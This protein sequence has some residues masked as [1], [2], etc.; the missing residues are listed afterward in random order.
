MDPERIEAAKAREL[1]Y[2]GK[3]C[4]N[5][6]GTTRYVANGLCVPCCRDRVRE[7]ARRKRAFIKALREEG[8]ND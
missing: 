6:H 5:G 8:G 1:Y 4:P 3:P 7:Q 2:E